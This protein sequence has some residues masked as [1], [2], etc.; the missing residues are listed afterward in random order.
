MAEQIK[1]GRFKMLVF[2]LITFIQKKLLVL[3]DNEMGDPLQE[4]EAHRLYYRFAKL[5]FKMWFDKDLVEE[6]LN[7]S[8]EAHLAV[9]RHSRLVINALYKDSNPMRKKIIRNAARGTFRKNL[10]L[11][12]SL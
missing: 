9:K 7:N 11:D 6:V 5:H 8:D 2:K 3:D 4:T 12:T 1:H 10:I